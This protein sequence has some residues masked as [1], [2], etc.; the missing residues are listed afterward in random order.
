MEATKSD[1]T[2]SYNYTVTDLREQLRKIVGD[3]PSASEITAD[4]DE[5]AFMM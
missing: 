2:Q 3:G 4:F 5:Y 1:E